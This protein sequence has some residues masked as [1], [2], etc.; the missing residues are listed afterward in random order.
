MS[1]SPDIVAQ[2][3]DDR[4]FPR[5]A[6]RKPGRP[7][8]SATKRGGKAKRAFMNAAL[9]VS[10]SG[11]RVPVVRVLVT[12]PEATAARADALATLLGTSVSG[13]LCCLI[14]ELPDP[15]KVPAAPAAVPLAPDEGNTGAVP[16]QWRPLWLPTSLGGKLARI[17]ARLGWDLHRFVG[18]MIATVPEAGLLVPEHR[19]FAGW[20]GKE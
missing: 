18:N 16:G 3:V 11:E 15:A 17:L 7:R 13:L 4:A 14:D 5:P 6:K 8:K 10:Q 1:L 12:M 9:F 20:E 19:G 2:M